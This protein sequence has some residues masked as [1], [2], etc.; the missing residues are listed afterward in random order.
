M[1]VFEEMSS[2][3]SVGPSSSQT[4]QPP[5]FVGDEVSVSDRSNRRSASVAGEDEPTTYRCYKVGCRASLWISEHG[6]VRTKYHD[7]GKWSEPAILTCDDEGRLKTPDRCR[8]DE[9]IG[10]AWMHPG[11]RGR[12]ELVQPSDGLCASNLRCVGARK[13]RR[14]TVPPCVMRALDAAQN[15]LDGDGGVAPPPSS[16]DLLHRVARSCN[17]QPSTAINY[18][19]KGASLVGYNDAAARAVDSR[20]AQA[21]SETLDLSGS[22][23]LLHKRISPLLPSE[24][25]ERIPMAYAHLRLGRL[26]EELRRRES[27]P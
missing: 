5:V 4:S 6:T 2:S 9:A 24:E 20:I 1:P 25:W 10:E 23:S 21:L 15:E 8:L 16:H 3:S 7:T 18:L 27:A 22:L 19:T 13:C 17:I 11:T 26:C 12:V 14:V